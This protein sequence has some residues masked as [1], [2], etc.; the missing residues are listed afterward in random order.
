MWKKQ[1]VP[2]VTTKLSSCFCA[3]ISHSV[4]V[5]FW[6]FSSL[7]LNIPIPIPSYL[8]V[9]AL[10]VNIIHKIQ[11]PTMSCACTSVPTMSCTSVIQCVMLLGGIMN[12][13]QVNSNKEREWNWHSQRMIPYCWV[14]DKV[15][16]VR[17]Q[18]PS[19]EPACLP[20]DHSVVHVG[21]LVAAEAPKVT[22]PN[23]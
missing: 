14:V 8:S 23:W 3:L 10:V 16:S 7:S 17:K 12:L 19:L 6:L 5:L 2:M 9:I 22:F 20:K 18:Q 13:M 21:P 1:L 4:M 11:V 15:P